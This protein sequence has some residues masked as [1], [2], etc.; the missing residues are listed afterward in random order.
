MKAN[1]F[2]YIINTYKVPAC[3]GRLICDEKGR[4]GMI[5]SANGPYLKCSLSNQKG[6]YYF[7][8]RSI[9]YLGMVTDNEKGGEK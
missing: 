9:T 7:H 6:V 1:E 4:E 5:L 3:R 8:P 2:D